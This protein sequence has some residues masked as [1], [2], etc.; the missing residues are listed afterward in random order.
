MPFY[1]RV[2]LAAALL[3]AIWPHQAL[4]DQKTVCTI[5]V[6]SPD[7][8]DI[9]RRSLP[10]DDYRFVELV[11]RG[12]PDWLASACRAGVKCDVLV[13]SGHFDGGVEFYSDRVDMRES[14]PVAEL[15]RAS[16][17]DS[18]P[19]LFSQ[20][21]EVYLFGC[22][23]LNGDAM[24]SATAEI[25]R[26]LVR[27]GHSQ[28]DADR[29]TRILNE[30]HA[31]SNRDRM[32]MIFKDV[33][34]L[35]GFSSK[36]PLGRSAGPVLERYFQAG[37]AAEVATGHP[38]AKLLG[39]FA[40]VSMTVTSGMTAS[41]PQAAYRADVCQFSDDRTSS[42]DKVTF[43]HRLL[44]REIAEVRMFLDAIETYVGSLTDAQRREPGVARAL[45]AIARD[46]A[47]RTRY[48]DFVH[49]ADQPS[50]RARMIGVAQ[51]LGW[52]TPAQHD[53]EMTRMLQTLVASG[54]AGPA[55]VDLVCALNAEGRLSRYL[56]ALRATPAQADK[57]AAA[58][59]L[60]CLG[61]DKGH[62]RIV[63]ALTSA[64]DEDVQLAQVYLRHRPIADVNEL[65][66]VAA[67][68]ARM[69]DSAAQVRALDTL[70]ALRLSDRQSLTEITRVFQ[71]AKSVSVQ[72]AVA[73]ILIRSDYQELDKPELVATL[74]QARLKSSEGAD[75]IDVLLRRLQAK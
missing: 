46:S 22:N 45:D 52:L 10:Q 35:Y 58:A 9:F 56:P 41:D 66:A 25:G 61:S 39:L 38:S 60:A 21:K 18:C 65:R 27:A 24:R 47:A 14:L 20:L 69:K 28:A 33:P 73:G 15:T 75:L 6:N 2:V 51:G 29:L 36:A 4:A 72:R 19:G 31:D 30:R 67:G 3:A 63:Q 13:I 49:D 43:V 26:S 8:K 42:A 57:A 62:A 71:S 11:E 12:R 16:C 55:E 34:V 23:T 32:R 50:V 44:G 54:T 70:A 53:A 64:N 74:R 7:E 37:G 59:M 1:A 48:L 68:I 17:S 40:P 5:T